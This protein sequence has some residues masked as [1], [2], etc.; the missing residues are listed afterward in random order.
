MLKKI[1]GVGLVSLAPVSAFA[2][3]T[4]ID[5]TDALAQI[6]EA[7]TAVLAVGLAIIALAAI[8]MAIR[9]VKASFF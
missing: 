5:T 2:Q 9:W 4:A 6:G 3:A 7:E 1:G 8:A